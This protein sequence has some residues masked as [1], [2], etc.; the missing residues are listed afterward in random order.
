V[1]FGERRVEF[2]S[3][4]EQFDELLDARSLNVE[5]RAAFGTVWRK[6]G[7]DDLSARLH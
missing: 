5:S 2:E 1:V 3:R 7:H 6:A 4:T